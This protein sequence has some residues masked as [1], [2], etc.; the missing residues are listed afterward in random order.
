MSLPLSPAEQR[1]LLVSI[2]THRGSRRLSPVQ[3]AELFAKARAN[4]ATLHECAAAV[5]LGSSAMVSR[6]LRLLELPVAVQQMADWGRSTTSLPF[7]AASE[8][9]R[10]PPEQHEPVAKAVV[11]AGLGAGETKQAVQR[12]LR[13]DLQAEEAVQEILK[14]RPSLERRYV[15]IGSFDDDSLTEALV[16]IDAD[17]RNQMLGVLIQREFA[18]QDVSARLEPTGFVLSGPQALADRLDELG[19]VEGAVTEQLR[20]QLGGRE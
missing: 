9:A 11:S 19:D 8:V 13:S 20:E 17:E 10:L 2:K 7:S 12:L 6:F 15:V 16:P 3:V 4:G 14:L 1:D 5:G 18:I